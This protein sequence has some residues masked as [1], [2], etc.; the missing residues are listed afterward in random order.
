MTQSFNT[1]HSWVLGSFQHADEC[2]SWTCSFEYRPAGPRLGCAQARQHL[3]LDGS[4]ASAPSC[5]SLPANVSFAQAPCAAQSPLVC[6]FVLY[7]FCNS[8]L[9]SGFLEL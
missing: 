4:S 2:S 5:E 6:L 8:F 9:R 7:Q 1:P 3:D